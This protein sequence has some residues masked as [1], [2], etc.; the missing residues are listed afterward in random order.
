MAL[1]FI[2]WTICGRDST[3]YHP[4]NQLSCNWNGTVRSGTSRLINE[5]CDRRGAVQCQLRSDAVHE[6]SNYGK[7][8]LTR[9]LLYGWEPTT[10]AAPNPE[11]DWITVSAQL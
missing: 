11:V 2:K 3:K 5:T 4:M 7:D 8:N 1:P 9:P 6:V 10:A